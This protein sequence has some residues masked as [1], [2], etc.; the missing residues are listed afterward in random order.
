LCLHERQ[1]GTRKRTPQLHWIALFILGLTV[2]LPIWAQ[3]E[4]GQ[5]RVAVTD[6]SGLPLPASTVA[7][8]SQATN[9]ERSFKTDDQGRFTFAH[10]PFGVYRLSV[11]HSG[12]QKYSE[13]VDVR[14]SI[15]HEV[16]AKMTIQPVSS[17]VNVS[18]QAT[19]LDAHR[20][21]VV[22]SVGSQMIQEQQ[23]A[24]PGR[25]ILELVNLQPG[26]IFEANGVLHPR[27]SEYQTLFVVDGVPMDENRSPGFAPEFNRN[28][29]Q[30]ISVLTA[31]YPAEYGR[32]LG[33][34]VE[35]TTDK[36][37]RQGFHGSAE[38][39]GGS[40]NTGGGFFSGSY[41]WKR[42]QVTISAFGNTTARYLDPPVLGNFTNTATLDGLTA[43]YD[44]DL[45][46]ADRIHLAVHRKQA[47]FEVPN[48]NLQQAA[49]QLQNRNSIEDFGQAGWD[50]LI[51]TNLLFTA[52]ASVEDL[53]ANLWSN[54][55]STP[56]IAAQQRGFRR[57]YLRASLS[58]SKKHHDLKFGGDAHYAPVTEALQYQITDP[59]YFDPGTPLAFN[60]FD[61]KINHD[62]SLFAQDTMRY[63]N[64]TLSAGLRYDHYSL[65]VNA[66][67]WS[68]RTG[69][70]WYWRKADVL[71][72]FSYD[73]VF[74]TPAMENILLA[75]SPQV[76]VV[77]TTV[78]RIPVQASRG[79][80]YEAGFSKG[81]FGKLRLDASFYRRTF[82]NYADDDVFLNTGISFPISFASADIKG[83]DVKLNLPQWRGWSGFL[84]YS[85][86]IGIAQ[87]PAV[88]GLFLGELGVI[89]ATGSFPITQDQRNT[90]RA[91]LR[92]QLHPRVWIAA[93]AQYGSGLP[94]E[95]DSSNIPG[96]IQQYGQQIV[97]KV[98]FSA[99]RVRPNFSLD[100]SLGVDVWK[101]EM[102]AVTFQISGQNLTGRLNVIDFAGLFSGTAIAAPRSV[103]ARLRY[104]F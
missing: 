88:G 71:F 64:L 1:H 58:A 72:R 100:A 74:I 84:S 53:S 59:T 51:S 9:T 6:P 2:W 28:D 90:A 8:L 34:V 20:T 56:I 26:W 13:L 102:R 73:R 45:S 77:D 97:D 7:I 63:G 22:Y 96:L 3:V 32:R 60:F 15:P 82:D 54:S 46:D 68:P 29:V 27:G 78:A 86:M 50:H 44:Q 101:H 21:G 52:R 87:L 76:D 67:A 81:I 16:T 98:N 10:L 23:S 31:D 62:Q 93:I 80:Y 66:S 103:D 37:I 18:D 24:E 57:S 11:E 25:S 17:A 36:D 95:A 49:G 33:G 85:N 55:L 79:N 94:S 89:G 92:Y 19:L 12:F 104:D 91:Y 38:A 42:S 48:E 4:T 43:E 65:V 14:S 83:V 39:D 99:G 47:Q 75:S 70:A 69:I 5:I 40:F 35:V 61:H 30:S 41:G